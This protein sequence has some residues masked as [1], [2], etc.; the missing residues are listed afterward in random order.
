[1]WDCGSDFHLV[2][3]NHSLRMRKELH[4]FVETSG[5]LNTVA[6]SL[7]KIANDIRLLGSDPRCGLGELI[8]PENEPGIPLN[9]RL[10]QWSVRRQNQFDMM[11]QF[12]VTELCEGNSSANRERISRLLHEDAVNGLM[13]HEKTER[14]A[15]VDVASP[16]LPGKQS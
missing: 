10:F 5:A 1:M 6:T 15:V 8:L 13:Q 14:T 16:S 12:E 2:L 3:V 7:M 11:V 9:A 4:T